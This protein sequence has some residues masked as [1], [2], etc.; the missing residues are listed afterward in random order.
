[1]FAVEFQIQLR[2]RV[3]DAS[4]DR[5]TDR[6]SPRPVLGGQHQFQRAQ[7]HVGHRDETLLLQQT[8]SPL[9]VLET[10]GAQQYT[11]P[12]IEFLAI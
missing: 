5:R 8:S 9:S 3:D 12:Q 2:A 6:D 1:M 10:Y 7:V 11:A 4:V